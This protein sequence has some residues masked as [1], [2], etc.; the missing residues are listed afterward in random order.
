AAER[1]GVPHPSIDAVAATRDKLVMRTRLA[2]HGV[3]QPAFAPAA[4]VES[5]LRVADDLGYPVVVKPR[6]LSASRGVIRADDP[7][8]LA[9]AWMRSHAIDVAA[10]TAT[11]GDLLV[12]AFVPG[13]EVAV[14][15]IVGPAGPEILAVFDKPDPLDGPFFEETIYVTPSQHGDGIGDL[16]AAGI[17]ALG[18][19]RGPVHAE[20]RHG[21]DGPVLIEIAARSIGG[22][23][24]RALTFGMLDG[25]LEE[26]I[27]RAA[28][29]MTRRGMDRSGRAAGVMMLPTPAEGVLEGIRRT[30][31]VAEVEG[32]TGFEITVTEGRWVRPLPEGDRYLGF[33]FAEGATPADVEASLREAHGLLD[34]RIDPDGTP[35]ADADAAC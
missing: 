4:S 14:E 28:L 35:T 25:S 17:D 5:A 1:L 20:V 10:G 12:E 8:D 33:L 31:A 3:P 21:P 27:I 18:I 30:E 24:S 7:D 22:L 23:C 19:D 26:Q 29:G 15:A 16:V 13:V 32:V 2:E 9:A 6:S 11:A 34:V